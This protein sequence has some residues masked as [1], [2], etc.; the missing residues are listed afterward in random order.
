MRNTLGLGEGR[1]DIKEEKHLCC[2]CKCVTMLCEDTWGDMCSCI[3]VRG[4]RRPS[5]ALW[6]VSP[7]SSLDTGLLIK[8]GLRLEVSN[9]QASFLTLSTAT[10]G[11][12][13]AFAISNYLHWFRRLEL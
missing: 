10:L 9:P 13:N 8:P 11:L 2:L 6:Y 12:H 1:E 4:Q 7:P 3:Q 5:G